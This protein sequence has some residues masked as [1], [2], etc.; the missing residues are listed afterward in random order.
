MFKK[1]ALIL[2]LSSSLTQTCPLSLAWLI[3]TYGYEAAKVIVVAAVKAVVL[4]TPT[5]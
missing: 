1:L 3:A 2:L 4:P 5:H